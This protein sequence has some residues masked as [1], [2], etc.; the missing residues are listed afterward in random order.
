MSI[1]KFVFVVFKVSNRVSEQLQLTAVQ[2]RYSRELRQCNDACPRKKEIDL[3]TSPVG[4]HITGEYK[5]A[6]SAY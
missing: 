6:I 3:L 4:Y 1:S 2:E 5:K